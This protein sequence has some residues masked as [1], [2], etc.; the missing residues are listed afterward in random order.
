MLSKAAP[1]TK[2]FS[3]GRAF[4]ASVSLNIPFPGVESQTTPLQEAKATT[5]VTTLANGLKVVSYNDR[6]QAVSSVGLY[7]NA[8]ASTENVFNSGTTHLLK[9]LGFKNFLKKRGL[10]LA[11]EA[12]GLG[13]AISSVAG[14]EHI[15][16]RAQAPPASIEQVVGLLH[17]MTQPRLY[18]YEVD[19]IRPVVEDELADLTTVHLALDTLHYNA[20]RNGGLGQPLA[21]PSHNVKTLAPEVLRTYL[22]KFFVPNRM[23]LAGV[24]V[25]HEV[26]VRTITE[27]LNTPATEDSQY[28]PQA[29]SGAAVF[30]FDA[31]NS[32]YTGG[33]ARVPLPEA[34]H[35][36]VAFKS[37]PINSPD[38]PVSRVLSSYLGLPG[39]FPTTLNTDLYNFA[40]S[41]AFTWPDR[42]VSVAGAHLGQP[43]VREVSSF[44]F[45][46]GK[47]GLAGVY[48]VASEGHVEQLYNLLKDHIKTLGSRALNADEL[49]RA[50]VGAKRGFQNILESRSCLLEF[51]AKQAA[52]G[53]V[54]KTPQELSQAVDSVTADQ[55][56]RVAKE[57]LAGKPTVVAVGDVRGLPNVEKF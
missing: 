19:E 12:E 24:G 28:R 33:E 34:T 32:V 5:K 38:L 31:Q 6:S 2:T 37:V 21:A 7:V 14:R 48:A 22:N 25:S 26:L 56:L 42:G 40:E 1:L 57:A 9:S 52:I 20:F 46:Y 29:G 23:V 55:V 41:K 44:D 47:T 17:S 30:E 27:L 54:V 4:Y 36:A 13:A 43:W 3:S 49:A 10:T 16:F 39:R 11:R 8:G 51:I 50:K 35:L 18:E 15:G 45:N 53:D